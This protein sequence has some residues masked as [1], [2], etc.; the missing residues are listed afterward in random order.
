MNCDEAR[1]ILAHPTETDAAALEEHLAGCAACRHEAAVER[2][3][4]DALGRLP[5]RAAP[6]ALLR[7]I[8]QEI[9]LPGAERPR[10]GPPARSAPASS[11]SGS[12]VRRAAWRAVPALASGLALAAS[13]SLYYERAVLPRARATAQLE[14]EAANDYLRILFSEHPIEIE[15]GGIH[16]VKPW[17]NGK[18]DFAPTMPFDGDGDFPLAGGSVSYFLDRKAAAYVFKR[19]KHLIPCFVFRSDGFSFPTA[20]LVP[21][22]R[23]LAHPARLR[24]I[25][26]L[27]WR[28]GELGYALV[29]DVDAADLAD[30]AARIAP[31]AGVSPR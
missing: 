4:T 25:N 23:V 8:E 17:F 9:A 31:G 5:R 3:L 10:G 16:Q 11:T 29:S 27:L 14:T 2:A 13:V 28:D 7:R 21:V 24:G 15:S 22:G 1:A 12:S 30:L 20:G 19:R 18:L 6:A 26:V